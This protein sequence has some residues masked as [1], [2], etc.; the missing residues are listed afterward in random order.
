MTEAKAP[1]APAANSIVPSTPK[2]A[3]AAPQTAAP[4]YSGTRHRVPVEGKE[5]EVD[6]EEMRRGYGHMTAANRRMQ[7]AA[8]IKKAA[9]QDKAY[10]E[11]IIK[12]FD[13]PKDAIGL[14]VEKYGPREAKSYLENWLIEQMEYDELPESEKRARQ[15]EREKSQ[16]ADELKKER[17]DKEAARKEAIEKRA[18]SDIDTEVGEAI[19]ASGR[20]PTPRMIIRVVDEMILRGQVMQQKVPAKEALKHAEEGI[21]ADISE[22]L[23]HTP[24]EVALKRL[25]KPFLDALRNH[26]VTQV[27]GEKQTRRSKPAEEPKP[28]TNERPMSLDEQ[29]KALQGSLTKQQ[30]RRSR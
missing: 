28:V 15:L 8:E 10:A 6:Y 12:R 19:E 9:S 21:W 20:K 23:T 4:D 1:A 18:H 24:P 13:D 11:G 25:P 14:L 26:E 2:P 5:I 29:F 7:E 17:A 27:L 16:L 3:Q 30:Q 22:Y